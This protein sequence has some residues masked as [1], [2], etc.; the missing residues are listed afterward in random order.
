MLE[1]IIGAVI[2]GILVGSLFG[3]MF[4]CDLDGGEG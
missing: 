1:F 2:F 3:L 4:T